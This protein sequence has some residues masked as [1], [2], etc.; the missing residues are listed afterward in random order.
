[1]EVSMALIF[2]TYEIVALGVT[3]IIANKVCNDCESNWLE[4][5]QLVSVYIILAATFFVV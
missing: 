1:M 5:L 3:V 4:G 2:N